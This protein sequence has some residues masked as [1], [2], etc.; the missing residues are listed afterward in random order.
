MGR[1]KKKPALEMTTEEAIRTLFPP[2]VIERIKRSLSDDFDDDGRP[3]K[4]PKKSG[5]SK[6]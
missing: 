1:R 4:K 5:K 3:N 6:K 2:K